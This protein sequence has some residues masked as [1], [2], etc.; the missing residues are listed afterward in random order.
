M[1]RINGEVA[2]VLLAL[3]LRS[4]SEAIIINPRKKAIDHTNY[5]LLPPP[6][7]A[8]GSLEPPQSHTNSSRSRRPVTNACSGGEIGTA[9][10]CGRAI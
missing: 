2:Q 6:R 3:A 5:A 9:G 1:S 10:L 4:T 7:Q 8:K